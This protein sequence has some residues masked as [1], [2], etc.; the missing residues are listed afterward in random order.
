MRLA[1][2]SEEAHKASEAGDTAEVKSIEEQVDH[3]AAKLWGLT[4]DE[5]VEIK[6]SLEEA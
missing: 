4:E 3:W 6:R 5:L 1:E 2:L